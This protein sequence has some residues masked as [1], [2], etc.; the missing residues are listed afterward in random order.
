MAKGS[1]EFKK[2]IL[3]ISFLL[4]AGG[5]NYGKLSGKKN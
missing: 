1:K 4:H 5:T 2:T 3:K